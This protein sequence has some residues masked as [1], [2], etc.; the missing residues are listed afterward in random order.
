MCALAFLIFSAPWILFVAIWIKA[1]SSGPTIFRQTRIGYGG[2][3][4]IIFKFRTMKNGSGYPFDTV[5]PNDNRITVPGK[6]L[7][8]T[9]MDELPQLINVLLGQMSLV[10]PRPHPVEF[11]EKNIQE[12]PAY[13]LRLNKVRPGLTGL[14]QI[15]GRVWSLKHSARCVF[16]LESFYVNHQCFLLD[17]CILLQTLKT[18]WGR[19][20]V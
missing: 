6:F 9:H 10:G 4:F 12:I 2:K 1:T 7:R 16:R 8:K 11:V 13:A 19:K 18:V 15:R 3:P 20:G 5:L 14:V 17:L